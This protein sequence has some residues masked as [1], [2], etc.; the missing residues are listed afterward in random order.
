MRERFSLCCGASASGWNVFLNG[1]PSGAARRKEKLIDVFLL[2]FLRAIILFS[3]FGTPLMAQ[4]SIGHDEVDPTAKIEHPVLESSV[5]QPLPEEFIWL[6]MPPGT[7]A[8]TD[9]ATPRYF[10]TTFTLDGV[11][12]QATLYISG[13]EHTRAF[14][15]GQAIASADLDEKSKTYPLVVIAAVGKNLR[16]GRNLV[17]VEARGGSP[18][19]VKIVPGA[20]G[21]VAPAFLISGPKWKGSLNAQPGWEQSGFD[22]SAW[23]TVRALGSIDASVDGYRQWFVKT[24]NLEWNSDSEMYRWPGYDGISPYLAHLWTA[25][26]AVRDV[27]EG[28]GHFENVGALTQPRGAAEFELRLPNA[29]PGVRSTPT[30]A[31][32]L[33]LDFGRE[34]NGR[35]EVTSDS[36]ETMRLALQYGESREEAIKSPYLGTN[37]L[38]VPPHATV[39]GPKSA[40]RYVQ[41]K[42]LSGASPF[43]FKSIRLD[44]IYYPVQYR[45]SFESSDALLNR[46]WS[47]GAYTSHLCMQDGIWD[48]PKRDRMPWMGDLDVSGDVIDAVF[49]DRFLMQNTMDRLITETGN[50]L[51]LD[52]NGI[53]GY[54]AF[55]VMGEADYYRHIGDKDYLQSIHD[56]LVRLLDYMAGELDDQNLFA[57]PRKAWPFVDWSPE[58][59]KDTPEARRAT[60]F[61]FYKAFSDGAW[62]L[63]ESGDSAAGEKY[64]A[65]AEAMR[66]AA[67]LVLVDAN[68]N[69]FGNRWQANAMAIYSGVADEKQTAAIWERV[70]SRPSQFMITPYY[71]YYV[72]SAMAEAGHRREALD[73]V[74]KYWGGMIHEGATSFWEG[75]DPTWPKED[76]HAN[77]QADDDKG[78]FV[79]LAHGWS[80]GATAWLAEQILGIRPR[81]GGFREVTIRPDLAGLEWARGA[82]PTPSGLIRVDYKSDAG[83]EAQIELP[84]G[85]AARVSMPVC[86]GENSV[87]VNQTRTTGESAEAGTRIIVGIDRPSHYVLHSNCAG[88]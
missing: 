45:G 50:P 21:E 27:A 40:F 86:Q 78:Y 59:D 77:L 32:S 31:A 1:W 22:D 28:T 19:A 64:Q 61:E 84:V 81:A 66:Q 17:A 87:I 55:W 53:P 62:V 25:A 58:F 75:Y 52:V 33:V 7:P 60:Q 37:E 10:R 71:N 74:R 6:A 49:A 24:S 38:V 20:E 34:T 70:L 30:E 9:E 8:K 36:E 23:Q 48:A 80:S 43:R 39:Y 4:S 82:V 51:T 42:F 29:A 88:R 14:V 44:A 67:Q 56:S 54:S 12:A 57:N 79:S 3:F 73:W 46:I 16:N 11:P 18:V 83:F 63:R 35:L 68:T 85:V 69:T 72:I 76:F 2:V 65:R 41:L 26:A 13:P 47:V 15:N 5:H